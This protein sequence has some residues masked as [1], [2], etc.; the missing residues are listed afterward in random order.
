[1]G[2]E[3]DFDIERL[4]SVLGSSPR[5]RGKL[6][7]AEEVL[8]GDRLIP[9]WAGK[10]RPWP[11][12][13]L[14]TR[15]HPRVGGE[16]FRITRSRSSGPGSSPRGRG[17]HPASAARRADPGLIPAWAG[18]TG[19]AAAAAALSWAHPRVGGENEVAVRV[20][21]RAAGSSPR[22]RGKQRH[23]TKTLTFV[24]LIP[25]WAGKTTLYFV[26]PLVRQ[27]HPRVGGENLTVES[28][29]L[30]LEGSSPRGRGKRATSASARR[31]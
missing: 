8:E 25:A 12:P 11:R 16:N 23:T 22:G 21:S 29:S 4:A 10:T 19:A 24:R 30:V 5:G 2:G 1:M 17:K 26:V 3:N 6:D 27:A 28:G 15:A 9:A 13:T 20:A 18:K 7:R 14:P 31:R